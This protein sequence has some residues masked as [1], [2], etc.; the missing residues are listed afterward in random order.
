MAGPEGQE[1]GEDPADYSFE[2]SLGYIIAIQS[3]AISFSAPA[4]GL[5]IATA[6]LS[7]TGGLRA[8]R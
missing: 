6:T 5:L 1:C 8:A 2:G 4:S 7:A 3:Q